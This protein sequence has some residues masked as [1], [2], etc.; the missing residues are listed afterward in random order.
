MF[1]EQIK[2]MYINQLRAR[3]LCIIIMQRVLC[4][5]S[6]EPEQFVGKNVRERVSS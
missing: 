3:V 4:E 5:R 1:N 2:Y 6:A